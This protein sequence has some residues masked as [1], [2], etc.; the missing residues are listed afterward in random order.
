MESIE[1]QNNF[2][3]ENY[4]KELKD[5]EKVDIKFEEEYCDKDFII[6]ENQY[7][8]YKAPSG[9]IDIFTIKN[10]RIY[11]KEFNEQ[12]K[13]TFEAQIDED[14]NIKDFLNKEAI[15]KGNEYN[16]DGYITYNG[17]FVNN[18]TKHFN[19]KEYNN[20]RLIFEGNFSYGE[21]NKGEYYE[22]GKLKYKG[23]FN[24]GKY[25]GEGEDYNNGQLIYKGNFKNGERNG[26]GVEYYDKIYKNEELKIEYEGEFKNNNR[27]GE[28]VIYD[29][30]TGKKLYE[31]TFDEGYFRKGKEY[32]FEEKL[33]YEGMFNQN[34]KHDG[35]GAKFDPTTGEITC[36][37]FFKNDKICNGIEKVEGKFKKHAFG[38]SIYGKGKV[39]KDYQLLYEGYLEND[40]SNGQGKEYYVEEIDEGNMTELE[41]KN[42]QKKKPIL[43][44]EGNFYYDQKTGNGKL[45]D[46]N[47]KKIFEGFFNN[48]Y[49]QCG[50]E[51][52]DKGEVVY[53]GTFTDVTKH[54]SNN[55]YID[56]C[57][58][59]KEIGITYNK[60]I[61]HLNE[62]NK[63]SANNFIENTKTIGSTKWLRDFIKD[64]L[65][66][67][68]ET[69]TLKR[70]N[71][72]ITF[73]KLTG[74]VK[75]NKEQVICNLYNISDERK[76]NLKKLREMI[77][78]K[79]NIS[80]E[81][82]NKQIKHKN[83]KLLNTSVIVLD[84]KSI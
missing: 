5:K 14:Y 21:R 78:K 37:G 42:L 73:D 16:N 63:T 75:N 28:G 66:N 76:Q 3:L 70:D 23:G 29:Q 72:T 4:L 54:Y 11:V 1:K 65:K 24:N 43:F 26:R 84:E 34:G 80:L 2:S 19:G 10:G 71:E 83:K 62:L 41:I 32:D 46:V 68:K 55:I 79:N 9:I 52:N 12:K 6:E 47:G 51:Y 18:K 8:Y 56:N 82:K 7:G 60:N 44:Y 81:N 40:I 67:N 50:V 38:Y 22:N 57:V 17:D 59:D 13:I 39:Y 48:N 20:G 33:V 58:G 64:S 15:C 31:G 49:L 53:I 25:D 35:S 61:A 74:D 69:C 27:H 36:V 77:N 45:F 30:T